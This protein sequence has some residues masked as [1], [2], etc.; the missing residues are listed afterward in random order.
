MVGNSKQRE[1][2][3]EV[4]GLQQR[5]YLTK[6]SFDRVTTKPGMWGEILHLAMTV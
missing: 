1:G 4:C 5:V 6:T 2:R 3:L